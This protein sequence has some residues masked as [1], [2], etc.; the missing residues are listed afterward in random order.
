MIN[1]SL[2]L[3]TYEVEYS[4]MPTIIYVFTYAHFG[5]RIIKNMRPDNSDDVS[6]YTLRNHIE[7]KTCGWNCLLKCL[8]WS[9]SI[10]TLGNKQVTSFVVFLMSWHLNCYTPS[11]CIVLTTRDFFQRWRHLVVY[12]QDDIHICIIRYIIV[13]Y[14]CC[15][16]LMYVTSLFHTCVG[17][18][19]SHK[20]KI[21]NKTKIY[22]VKCYLKVQCLFL[23]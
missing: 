4:L 16:R 13:Q 5:A 8:L 12:I 1:A 9:Y 6:T 10:E 2:L 11:W 18:Y 7:R 20:K 21:V 17:M 23:S 19:M 22:R 15:K 3:T 14:F